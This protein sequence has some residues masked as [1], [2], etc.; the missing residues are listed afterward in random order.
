MSP[1]RRDKGTQRALSD[2][3]CQAVDAILSDCPEL[4]AVNV[5]R[6]VDK[7]HLRPGGVP[8]DS[9][10][11]RYIRRMRPLHRVPSG[12]E[13]RAFEAPYA[14]CLYQ[15]DIMYGPHV[16]VKTPA[17]RWRKHQTYLIAVLD[18]HSRLLCHGEFFLSQDLIS[19]LSTL[20]SAIRKRGIP[21]KIYCD[22]GKVFLSDQVK[23]IGA[24][25]GTRIVHTAVR[26]AAAKG[27]IERFFKTVRD[28]FLELEW[29]TEKKRTLQGLNR[30]FGAWVEQYNNR[31]HSALGCSPLEKWLQSPRHPR[32]LQDNLHSDDLFLLETSRRVRKDGTFQLRG[33]RYETLYV[34]AG[35]K[36]DVRYDPRDGK[37]VHVYF[38]GH[39]LGA[40][41]RLDLQ[42]NYRLPRNRKDS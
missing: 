24:E 39:Y 34:Y 1:P 19:Y 11:Y 21:D 10:L 31:V 3:I 5:I 7:A 6:L 37:R 2:R 17:G 8:S 16:R 28:H 14:G 26:D 9:T 30:R 36:V 23:R 33:R 27:K 29:A 18:D 22:N 25:I 20:E 12:K 35:R 42:A 13:R 4:R 41:R 15:V 38:E 40:A 32:L